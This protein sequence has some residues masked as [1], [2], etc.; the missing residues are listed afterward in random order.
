M[1]ILFLVLSLPPTENK[2]I[3]FIMIYR[4]VSE[5]HVEENNLLRLNYVSTIGTKGV[6]LF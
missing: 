2:L 6:M 4:C 1:G 5:F 3:A